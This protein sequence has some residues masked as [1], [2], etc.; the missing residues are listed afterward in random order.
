MLDTTAQRNRYA[1]TA[2]GTASPQVLLV[3]LYDRLVL[4]LQR[5]EHAQREKDRLSAN[6]QLQHAQDIVLALTSALDVAAWSGGPELKALYSWLLTE[7]VQANV[8]TDAGRTAA[9]RAVV[10]PLRDAWRE[11]GLLL[12]A[13]TGTPRSAVPALG[14]TA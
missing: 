6:R 2:H 10:E 11:A 4:D 3:L 14:G 9:C 1:A 12:A 7:M 8:N 5:A 13:G